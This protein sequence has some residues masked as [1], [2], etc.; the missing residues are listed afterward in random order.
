MEGN[1]FLKETLENITLN[2]FVDRKK[3]EEELDSWKYVKI[4][5]ALIG[6]RGC[7][8]STLINTLRNLFPWDKDAAKVG[9]T[10]CTNFP[11]PYLHP[12]NENLVMWDLPGFGT[13]KWPI[14]TYLDD[15]TH[16]IV[17]SKDPE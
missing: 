10:E 1:S 16:K 9:V 5:I 8:K 2:K 13:K 6:D 3:I 11:S 17:D 12:K 7:G 4:N 15:I 14:E